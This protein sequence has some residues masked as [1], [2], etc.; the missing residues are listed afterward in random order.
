LRKCGQIVEAKE[1]SE[2]K[3]EK[4][5][6]DRKEPAIIFPDPGCPTDPED[7][8]EQDPPKKAVGLPTVPRKTRSIGKKGEY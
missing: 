6:R 2:K 1:D 5:K 8:K 7:P 3:E 4:K